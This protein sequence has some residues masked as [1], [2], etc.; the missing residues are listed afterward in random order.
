MG[1]FRRLGASFDDGI[2]PGEWGGGVGYV[3]EL[4]WRWI[5]YASYSIDCI[6]S[7][8]GILCRAGIDSTR[9]FCFR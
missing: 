3:Y 5:G 1:Y 2:D 4:T 7:L 8:C 6:L 9:T